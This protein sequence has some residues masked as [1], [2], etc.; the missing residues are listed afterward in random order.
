MYDQVFQYSDEYDNEFNNHF[1]I[2]E[3]LVDL[4]GAQI[5][6][7]EIYDDYVEIFLDAQYAM[8]NSMYFPCYFL[9]YEAYLNDDIVSVVIKSSYDGGNHYYSVYNLDL[10]SGDLRD[11]HGFAKKFGVSYLT[12][13]DRLVAAME[14]DYNEHW[15]YPEQLDDADEQKE[16]TFTAENIDSSLL[17][18]GENGQLMAVYTAYMS[19]GASYHHTVIAVP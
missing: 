2:P 9:D 11:I 16:N 17:F 3:F 18:L 4:P 8:D 15:Y 7:D 5:A 6:N 10:S 19:V 13:R 1:R 12:L 14:D